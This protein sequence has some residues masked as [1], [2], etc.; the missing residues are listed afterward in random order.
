MHNISDARDYLIKHAGSVLKNL[1]I[2]PPTKMDYPAL[3]ISLDSIP[4]T[5]AD[6]QNYAFGTQYMLNYITTSPTN[7]IA[8]ELLKIPGV[9]FVR[10]YTG[11]D[12]FYYFIFR[13]TLI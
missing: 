13:L 6:D 11:P 3:L 8:F 4:H 2:K 1:Y 9:S 10:F 5:N 7:D 12:N